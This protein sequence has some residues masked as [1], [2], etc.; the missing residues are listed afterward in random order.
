MEP[1]WALL[2]SIAYH[3]SM[4]IHFDS[5]T[6]ADLARQASQE[7]PLE[8]CGI[9]VGKRVQVDAICLERFRSVRSEPR[10]ST[11]AI[12]PR[13]TDDIV[14]M[15][16]VVVVGIVPAKNI[17][18]GDRQKKYQIDWAVLIRAVRA[19]RDGELA[20]LVSSEL[21][22]NVRREPCASHGD[23][24]DGLRMVGFYHSH[25]DGSSKPSRF[26]RQAGW[27][28]YS[29]VI[30]SIQP[31]R[32]ATLSSWFIACDAGVFVEEEVVFEGSQ[33]WGESS[34]AERSLRRKGLMKPR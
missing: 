34:P 27:S 14:V 28:G 30:V 32:S 26:D 4:A 2:P 6:V 1:R 17:A 15:G 25:P 20:D 7:H 11:R 24:R 13:S 18:D 29:Y 16:S 12:S 33:A 3:C 31:D 9:L 5:L 19:E 10:A 8:C 21:P 22:G 23:D